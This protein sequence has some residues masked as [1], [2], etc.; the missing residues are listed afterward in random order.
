MTYVLHETDTAQIPSCIHTFLGLAEVES[1]LQDR[2]KEEEDR[3]ETLCTQTQSHNSSSSD[4]DL[5][6]Q[7]T[8]CTKRETILWQAFKTS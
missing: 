7:Y 5:A 4:R 6:M 8:L 1:F 2:D 3:P